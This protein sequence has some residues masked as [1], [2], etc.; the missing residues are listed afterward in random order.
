ML[1][2]IGPYIDKFLTSKWILD[3]SITPQVRFY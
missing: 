1:I 2:V 3:Y